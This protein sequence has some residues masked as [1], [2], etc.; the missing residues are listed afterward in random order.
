[1]ATAI[2]LASAATADA[3]GPARTPP[4]LGLDTF[5]TQCI[6][7]LQQELNNLDGQG[8]PT[9]EGHREVWRASINLRRLAEVLLDGGDHAGDRG[10]LAVLAGFRLFR[11][12]EALD[13]V[14]ATLTADDVDANPPN[15]RPRPGRGADGALQALVRFNAGAAFGPH[16][17]PADGGEGDGR[18]L[19][20]GLASIVSPLDETVQLLEPGPVADH[21]LSSTGADTSPVDPDQ[22][23]PAAHVVAE[24]TLDEISRR[25]H[26]V[27][28]TPDARRE[29]ARIAGFLAR[30]KA[31]AEYRKSVEEYAHLLLEVLELAEAVHLADWLDERERAVFAERIGASLTLFGTKE[32]R[33]EGKRRIR[34]LVAAGGVI[35][36]ISDLAE[37]RV[38]S[39]LVK[40]AFLAAT[41]EDIDGPADPAGHHDTLLLVLDRMVAYRETGDSALPRD[42][43]AV[44]RRLDE[45]YRRAEAALAEELSTLA[46]RPDALSD[47]ALGTLVAVHKQSLEDLRRI[48]KVPTWVDAISRIQPKAAGPFSGRVRRMTQRMLDPNRRPDAAAAMDRFERQ[49]AA[50]HPLP[51]EDELRRGQREAVIATG[52]LH[53]QLATKIDGQRRK[54]AEAWSAGAGD[55]AAGPMQALG[56]LTQTMADSVD[57]L[58]LDGEGFLLN[59]WAAWELSAESFAR[60]VSDLVNR[61]KLAVAAAIDGDMEGLGRQLDR[62]DAE[63]PFATLIGRLTRRLGAALSALPSGARS[64]AGQAAQ[65]PPPG[66]WMLHRRRDVADLCRYAMELEYARATGQDELAERL[67]S[68]VNSLARALLEEM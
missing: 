17:L 50:F 36:R 24:E 54:W 5:A 31:F 44:R 47:P 66:A 11:G 58:R 46:R 26:A 19:D 21:W 35:G 7:V 68:Y 39:R 49:L 2:T 63:A 22:V 64:I 12:R 18:A 55:D 4:S 8:A 23:T 32:T 53:V 51:F 25:L 60:T 10:S 42:L 38:D 41:T 40:S 48:E 3:R 33:D 14:L 1:V 34:R 45:A 37:A 13:H 62:I 67:A 6:S 52:G 20:R 43:R 28:L 65:L 59:R 15:A 29:L 56:R 16:E 9:P 27:T 30:G 61:L 57:V